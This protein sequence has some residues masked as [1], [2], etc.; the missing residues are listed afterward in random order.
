VFVATKIHLLRDNSIHIKRLFADELITS[1][2]RRLLFVSCNLFVVPLY[3][4]R[5]TSESSAERQ[6]HCHWSRSPRVKKLDEQHAS[7]LLLTLKRPLL[8]VGDVI[9]EFFNKP[10]MMK[11]VV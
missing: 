2:N 1:I 3:V 8:V 10:K 5:W 7:S 4:V 9:V 11:K 6:Q